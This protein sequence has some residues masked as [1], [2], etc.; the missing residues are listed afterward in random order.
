MRIAQDEIFGPVLS[1]MSWTEEREAIELANQTPY[2]LTASIWTN[3]IDRALAAAQRIEAGY[4]WVNDVETRYPGLP[5]G[6]WKQSGIGTE[7]ALAEELLSFTRS[8]SVSIAVR[9]PT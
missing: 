4:V 5:F 2:G 9:E 8:K 6:G 3:D 7:Q 1:V